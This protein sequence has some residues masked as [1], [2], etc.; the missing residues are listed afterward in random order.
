[1]EALIILSTLFI[2]GMTLSDLRDFIGNRRRESVKERVQQK[3]HFF[4]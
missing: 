4:E 3:K 1:M 2:A